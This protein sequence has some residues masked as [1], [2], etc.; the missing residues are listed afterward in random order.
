MSYRVDAKAFNI[1]RIKA[2]INYLRAYLFQL[3]NDDFGLSDNCRERFKTINKKIEE[4]SVGMILD[5][6]GVPVGGINYIEFYH[7]NIENFIGDEDFTNYPEL[8]TDIRQISFDQGGLVVFELY[9]TQIYKLFNS[10][11]RL[12]TGPCH[13]LD[14]LINGKYMERSSENISG[15]H[16]FKYRLL[17]DS[18][19][20]I[21]SFS[22]F[23]SQKIFELLM[24]DSRDRLQIEV[25]NSV[26]ERIENFKEPK[27]RDEAKL[28]LLDSNCN[29]ITSP[30]LLKFYEQD[31]ELALLAV[32]REQLAYTLLSKELM[33]DE[34]IQRT[35]CL[36]ATGN[37]LQ[38]IKEWVIP[39][40]NIISIK[41]LCPVI[42]NNQDLLSVLSNKVH[43]NVECLMAAIINDVN[44][45][46][47][48]SVDLKNDKS[49][50]L[51]AVKTNGF[52]FKYCSDSL[53]N[54]VEFICEL[55]KINYNI[56]KEIDPVVIEENEIL[57]NLYID[58][59]KN[60]E[61]DD[62]PF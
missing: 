41:H 6:I 29:W 15:F 39:I 48:A 43:S 14:I 53:R 38:Y 34:E 35:L 12:I 10:N 5:I 59:K 20:H 42:E 7:F 22:D 62:L 30:E 13:D 60:Q 19:I 44:N 27:S 54:D 2:D 3:M 17:T 21:D 31:K 45:M 46:K 32:S 50:V 4:L 16:L 18:S 55:Y 24:L 26:P 11:G 61:Q 37:L 28:I 40:E 25:G 8:F 33:F 47:Y 49:F 52:A 1:K 23:D 57:K 58:Y 36:N 9:G 51:E 56:I